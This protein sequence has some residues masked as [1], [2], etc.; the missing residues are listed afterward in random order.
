MS[1]GRGTRLAL[2]W[3]LT[4]ASCALV[5]L[6]AGALGAALYI[7]VGY[8]L[9]VGVRNRLL[10]AT[11][12]LLST[13][14]GDD[15][16]G[17]GAGEGLTRL[18]ARIHQSN[19]LAHSNIQA[20]I[21]GPTGAPLG[22]PAASAPLPFAERLGRE[23]RNRPTCGVT[24]RGAAKQMVCVAA[25][26]PAEAEDH[27]ATPPAPGSAGSL[28]LFSSLR[29]VEATLAGLRLA[30]ALGLAGTLLLASVLSIPLARVALKPLSL[31]AATAE[32]IGEGDLSRR[33]ATP[34]PRDEVRDLALAFN[35][36]LERIESAFAVQRDSEARARHFAADV[37]HE[38][39]SPLT[40]LGG[41]VD[42]LLLDAARS[43]E[44]TRGILRR[45]QDEI[46]RLTRLVQDLLTLARMDAA[47]P[48]L[49]EHEA[50]WVKDVVVSAIRETQPLAGERSMTLNMAPGAAGAWVAGDEEQLQRLLFNLLDNA[51]R[52]TAPRG[53]I[54]VA[55]STAAPDAESPLGRVFVSVDDNGE[56]IAPEDLP[57]IFDR[58]YRADASRARNTGNAGLG[59]AI[60]RRT[61]DAH[62][63]TLTVQSHLGVG[64]CFTL[65]LPRLPEPPGEASPDPADPA[66]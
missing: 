44:E 6:L 14:S 18:K 16:A 52:H 2:R 64:S 27:A 3:R 36:M 10:S 22:T 33:V 32:Q 58:F 12:L 23:S 26:A 46:R 21:L 20:V 51:I 50:V 37:S 38:L 49:A 19:A 47:S 65:A 66:P 17:G 11:S 5:A 41:S 29:G 30:L 35:A 42:V 1:R 48:A 25:L 55:V 60:A 57:H 15:L 45:M 53:A 9:Q 43:P 61:A 31:M 63:G 59:L 62:G 13:T 39:R 28:V 24:G 34:A 54:R 8:L 4:I 7:Q 56:G 40:A